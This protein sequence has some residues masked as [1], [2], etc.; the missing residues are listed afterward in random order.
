MTIYL[1]PANEPIN[2]EIYTYIFRSCLV[3][4]GGIYTVNPVVNTL[5]KISSECTKKNYTFFVIN[6]ILRFINDR[7]HKHYIFFYKIKTLS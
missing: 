6:T 7:R 2:F 3:V 5:G 4:Y 1:N